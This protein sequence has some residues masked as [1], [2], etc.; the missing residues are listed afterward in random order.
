MGL[1]GLEPPTSRLSGVRSNHLSYRPEPLH[2]EVGGARRIRTDD[3]L[4]AKQVL[5]QL[6]YSPL[7]QSNLPATRRARYEPPE[8]N[9]AD[10]L[11]CIL[12][13]CGAGARLPRKV[14]RCSL[15][16]LS[17]R[18]PGIM[19]SSETPKVGFVA[20]RYSVHEA[21]NYPSP[22]G[23]GYRDCTLK[24]GDPAAGSPTAT[25]LRLHPSR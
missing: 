3:P 19:R 20:S 8:S 13:G 15:Q 21:I 9:P 18:G 17:T 4:R 1:G 5:S 10:G 6:S 7:C 2:G 22:K 12:R 16:V 24:G 23:S 14:S 25:L 11:T